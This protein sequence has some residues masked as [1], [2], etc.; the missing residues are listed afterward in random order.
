MAQTTRR[1]FIRFAFASLLAGAGTP[2]F[3][4]ASG[5]E[6]TPVTLRIGYQKSS[7]LITLL[8]TRGSLEKALAALA[9]ALDELQRRI[10]SWLAVG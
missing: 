2:C 6:R 7:T 8:K 1:T 5:A 4:Q 10:E 3:A 9:V